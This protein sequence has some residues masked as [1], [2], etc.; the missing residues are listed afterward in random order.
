M[1]PAR[2]F[3]HSPVRPGVQSVMAS[4]PR[5]R[6]DSNCICEEENVTH[7]MRVERIG[8]VK[9]VLLC[10]S[11]GL[12]RAVARAFSRGLALARYA[13]FCAFSLRPGR[14]ALS[15][16]D[17]VGRYVFG[18]PDPDRIP[19]PDRMSIGTL[20]AP[21]QTANTPARGARTCGAPQPPT[22]PTTN[23]TPERG[24]AW[25]FA[26]VRDRPGQL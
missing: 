7:A 9:C 18:A 2:Q 23:Q 19:D 24:Q 20:G 3:H 15:R 16:I 6:Y 21:N 25:R 11:S 22:R 5:G 17:R 13:R 12:A 1:Q 26:S 8:G 10:M 4:P 14:S